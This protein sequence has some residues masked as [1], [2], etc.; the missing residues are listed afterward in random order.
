VYSSEAKVAD[1]IANNGKI[2]QYMKNNE[3][4]SI[5]NITPETLSRILT[6]LK[7]EKIITIDEHVATI[8]DQN[9]LHNI[10]ENN[11]MKKYTSI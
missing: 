3:I 6:K 2:F 5:L 11:T 8:L 10:I 1:L 4:A 7:K 9:R